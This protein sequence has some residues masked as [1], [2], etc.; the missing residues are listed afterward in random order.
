MHSHFRIGT[1]PT[2]S[3]RPRNFSQL[4]WTRPV[5]CS[6]NTCM[7]SGTSSTRP[8]TESGADSVIDNACCWGCAATPSWR[9]SPRRFGCILCSP[10]IQ[11]ILAR[12][13]RSSTTIVNKAPAQSLFT[14]YW[15]RENS[16]ASV[17]NWHRTIAYSAARIYW[18]ACRITRYM[19]RSA[20]RCFRCSR[21]LIRCSICTTPMS[22]GSGRCGL[23]CRRPKTFL[24]TPSPSNSRPGRGS[25]LNSSATSMPR[26]YATSRSST[27]CRPIVSTIPI[28]R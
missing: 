16:S 27:I 24:V 9:S 11:G 21:Q 22:I 28:I 13:I 17:V 4:G 6:S 1:G 26:R 5:I 7:C 18:R 25:I 15:H 19:P 14:E 23:K 8:W 3:A 12:P 20:A 10:T 2:C